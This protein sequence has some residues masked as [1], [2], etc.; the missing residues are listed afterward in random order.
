M[1]ASLA[2]AVA[3]GALCG[4]PSAASAE[5]GDRDR[6]EGADA[7]DDADRVDDTPRAGPI[8]AA[9]L[10][11]AVLHGAGHW[12]QGHR[13]TA[14]RLLAIEGIGIA[15]VLVGGGVL[16]ATGAN[17]I[18][19]GPAA[20]VTIGGV[21]LFASSY[22]ADVH[23]VSTPADGGGSPRLHAPEL[24][25]ELGYRY[26]HDPQFRYRSFLRQSAEARWRRL[27]VEQSGWFA[28]DD[29][30]ARLRLLGGVRLYGPLP[31]GP[32]ARDG[33][34]IEVEAAAT[35]H[36][37][38]SDGFRTLT[39]ELVV[40]SRIDLVRIDRLL[41]GAFVEI[42]GGYGRQAFDLD[43]P[44]HD[45]G[46]DASDLLLFR[47]AFGWYVGRGAAPRGEVSIYYDHRHDDF[48]AGLKLRGV[49]SGPAGHF[50][51]GGTVFFAERWGIEALAEVG[52][53]WVT[54]LGL[55]YR[56]GESE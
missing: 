56:H 2:C 47:S 50:G 30:N 13:P 21:G 1:R 17:R 28:L 52:S 32:P 20:A 8:V 41:R 51:V 46:D 16:A 3:L 11:G 48:A 42:A 55:V 40:S 49:A 5:S 53:A 29:E 9:L 7:G 54:G 43:V 15:L 27:R 31:D 36:A 10:P 19:V 34:F 6:C 4:L 14:Y 24:R 12:V 39:G 33:T 45:L 25:S 18:I 35:H 37:Y 26:V 23:G 38:S 22:L 44:G